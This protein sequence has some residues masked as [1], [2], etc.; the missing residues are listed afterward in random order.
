MFKV[1]YKDE[2]RKVYHVFIGEGVSDC[3]LTY[4]NRDKK[5]E[6]IDIDE[7]TPFMEVY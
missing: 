5:W 1:N 2:V 4:N 7:T 6:W 3:F